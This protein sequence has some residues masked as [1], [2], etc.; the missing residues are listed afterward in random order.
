MLVAYVFTAISSFWMDLITMC[1]HSLSLRVIVLKYIL[2]D[3]NIA[4]LAFFSF[5]IYMECFFYPL[6]Q[7]EFLIDSIDKG[8]V[9]HSFSHSVSFFKNFYLSIVNL[10]SC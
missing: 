5:F 4:I 8:L 10:Q 6:A 7:S 1:W 3:T 9:F 2:S